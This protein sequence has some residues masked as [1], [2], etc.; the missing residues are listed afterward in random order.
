MVFGLPPDRDLLRAL[1]TE[2]KK[3]CGSGGTATHDGV[4]IQGDRRGRVREV[5]L[6]KGWIVKGG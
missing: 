6:A 1:A 5:L 4:E 3:A 2:L